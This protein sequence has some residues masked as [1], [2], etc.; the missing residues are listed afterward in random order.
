VRQFSEAQIN[1]ARAMPRRWS[2]EALRHR[3]SSDAL[4]SMPET[5]E[6]QTSTDA[7]AD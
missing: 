1:V 4:L 2:A 3:A 7:D 5:R 6:P